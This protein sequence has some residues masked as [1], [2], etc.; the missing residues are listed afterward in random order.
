MPHIN[1]LPW[2]QELRKRR[3]REFGIASVAAVLI[4]AGVVLL[5]HLQFD[6]LINYQENRNTFLQAQIARL[7]DKIKEIKTLDD[8]KKRLLAR[9]QIIQRLQ[10]SRP[11]IV[12]LFD[13][14][15]A[16]IPDGL[17]FDKISQNSNRISIDGYAES[18]ARVSSVM[19]GLA[20]SPWLTEPRLMEIKADAKTERSGLRMNRFSLQI[21]QRR[22]D[23]QNNQEGPS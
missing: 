15:V 6:A 2:R 1:L 8:E 12:Y 16:A 5:V 3:Q 20:R 18:N 11:E 9:M 21:T 17:Y 10:A 13:E 19:R 23:Q 14:L 4:T 7:D 22:P